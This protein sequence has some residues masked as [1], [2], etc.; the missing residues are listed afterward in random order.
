MLF[1]PRLR[2]V[3]ALMLLAMHINI[4]LLTTSIWYVPS[5]LFLLVYAL[6]MRSGDWPSITAEAR[7][8]ATVWG[9]AG[10]LLLVGCAWLTPLG[11]YARGEFLDDS[12][13]LH[14]TQVTEDYGPIARGEPCAPGWMVER[15]ERRPNKLRV[16]CQASGG[17]SSSLVFAFE[18][19]ASPGQHSIFKLPPAFKRAAMM[20]EGK[21]DLATLKVV[22][23][24]LAERLTTLCPNEDTLSECLKLPADKT[25]GP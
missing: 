10:L 11:A 3:W 12:S 9:A 2:T 25:P 19:I 17:G 4:G 5:M 14:S 13:R 15:V 7:R 24:S 1:W 22:G 8:R 6:P 20:Y 21:G 16:V 18:P 23:T